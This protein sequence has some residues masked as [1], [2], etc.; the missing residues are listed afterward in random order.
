M[1]LNSIFNQDN[2]VTYEPE[3]KKLALRNADRT[4]E[5]KYNATVNVNN[6]T[7]CTRPGSSY[8][9]AILLTFVPGKGTD[10]YMDVT[11]PLRMLVTTSSDQ[12]A[13]SK[14]CSKT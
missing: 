5:R 4:A 14:Y 13:V 2:T 1:K 3:N 11:F 6:L 12:H 9:L 10:S 7:V 8:T